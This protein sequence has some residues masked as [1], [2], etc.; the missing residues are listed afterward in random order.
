MTTSDVALDADRKRGVRWYSGVTL[1][2]VV[3]AVAAVLL[4][5]VPATTGDFFTGQLGRFLVFGLAA[6]GL[7]LI[8]GYTGQLSLGHASFFGVGA[9]AAGLV[10]VKTE[11]PALGLIALAAGILLPAFLAFVMG[12]V[13]F[14]GNVVGAYFAIVTLLVS[15]ILEQTAISTIQLTGGINGLYGM[16]PL[17]FGPLAVDDLFKSYY[18]IVI[19]CVLAY[20]FCRILVTSPL[21]G[22]MAGVRTN[23][24]RVAS[25]GYSTAAIRTLVFTIGGALAGLAGV[26]YVPLE[27]FVYPSQLGVAFSTSIIVWLAIGGRRSLVGA[28]IGAFIVN[29]GQSTLSDRYQ[30][31]WVLATG[32]FLVLVVLTQP[33]GLVG[34]IE[35]AV[36]FARSLV[37]EQRERA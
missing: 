1:H 25:L 16:K 4:W 8:W 19:C 15:L 13:L 30:E 29:Y 6:L 20:V 24:R 27:A 2:W 5:M 32:V 22:A 36:R 12:R 11:W 33:R 9:Y 14:Y 10:L 31:Y 18:F 28:F 35:A 34:T 26:L 21:G 37:R 17:T 7:D 3:V 23:E